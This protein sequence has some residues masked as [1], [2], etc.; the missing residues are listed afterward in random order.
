MKVI[1]VAEGGIQFLLIIFK[2]GTLYWPLKIFLP[3]A[4]GLL[5]VAVVNY[6]DTYT[7]L[8]IFINMSTFYKC[9][10]VYDGNY[11]VSNRGYVRAGYRAHVQRR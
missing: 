6:I 11:R 4:V 10:T 2:A 5:L 3:I 7:T 8:S 9:G 1:L